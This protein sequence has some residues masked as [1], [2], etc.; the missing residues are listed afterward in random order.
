MGVW[1]FAIE[2][3]PCEGFPAGDELDLV[4]QQRDLS[5]IPELR[6]E[7][8]VGF[9][10]E[11]EIRSVHPGEAIILEVDEDQGFAGCAG[12]KQ[13]RHALGEEAGLA[14]AAHANYGQCLARN[15]R[16]PDLPARQARDLRNERIVELQA[17][18]V[19]DF[20]FHEIAKSR[21]L[22]F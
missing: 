9:Q 7:P 3:A 15:R 6:V 11:G 2:N 1:S 17:E 12:G 22:S 16:Q 8:V 21:F 18:G 10:K 19:V 14:A 4:E 5:V 20:S 13:V